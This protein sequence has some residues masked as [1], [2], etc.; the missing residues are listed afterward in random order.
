MAVSFSI[1]VPVYNKSKYLRDCIDSILT[2]SHSDFE[3]IAVNDGS[4]DSSLNILNSYDDSR[5]K[6]VTVC[7]GGVSKARNIGIELSTKEYVTFVD[8]DDK[9]SKDYLESFSKAIE[10]AESDII[11]GGLTKVHSYGEYHIVRSTLPVGVIAK[12]DFLDNFIA[13]MFINEGIFGYVAAKFVRRSILVKHGL[14]FD[15]TIK[16]AEDLDFWSKAYLKVNTITISDCNG[17]L[18]LQGTENS[19]YNLSGQ[20]LSQLIIWTSILKNYTPGNNNQSQ[21]VFRKINGIIEA[22]FLELSK[23]TLTNIKNN[24]RIVHGYVDC[25]SGDLKQNT[26][27]F[28]QSQIAKSNIY[29]LWLYL[30]CRKLYHKLRK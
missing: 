17:Y 19:T 6:T 11:I 20:H 9:L 25:Y 23:L 27:N 10:L 22:Y 15:S 16:L 24:L 13:Q 3:I 8:G 5:L 7:N 18:Y 1:I 26:D 28:L 14:R 12:K 29:V 30:K 21:V 2:Q 4:T